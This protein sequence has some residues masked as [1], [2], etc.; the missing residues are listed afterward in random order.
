[1][2]SR[3]PLPFGSFRVSPWRIAGP[4]EWPVTLEVVDRIRTDLLLAL[5]AS[6]YHRAKLPRRGSVQFRFTCSAI[7]VLFLALSIAACSGGS[8]KEG[9]SRS[10]GTCTPTQPNG[11]TPPGWEENP[12]NH[13][14]GVI[15]TNLPPGGVLDLVRERG[16]VL[17]DGSLAFKFGWE[18]PTSGRFIIT[19]SRL[20]RS[21]RPARAH[22]PPGYE[23]TF[24]ASAV[25]FPAP[26]PGCWRVTARV[27]E[28][29]LS[30]VV[31][32]TR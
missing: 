20:D 9:Y 11:D 1:M 3:N 13:G 17:E 21:D 28:A 18:R 2:L 31:R 8:I 5:V 22:I 26:A 25:I 14:N 32:V 12:S 27:G 4:L 23:G 24:Q 6:A 7:V 29:S 15:W 16:S 10:D 19:G 30:F